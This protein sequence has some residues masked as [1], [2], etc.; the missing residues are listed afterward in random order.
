M[1]VG[2]GMDFDNLGVDK[3]VMAKAIKGCLLL[4]RLPPPLMRVSLAFS[5]IHMSIVLV[6][7]HLLVCCNLFTTNIAVV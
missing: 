3:L 2:S 7:F 1:S 4:P 6:V 5:N